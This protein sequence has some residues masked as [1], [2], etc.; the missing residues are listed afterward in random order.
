MNS[1]QMLT[2]INPENQNGGH[3]VNCTEAN[4]PSTASYRKLK[5]CHVPG[6]MNPNQNSISTDVLRTTARE[7]WWLQ[8]VIHLKHS[9]E[10]FNQDE[11]LPL[12]EGVQQ[13]RSL[14]AP[15]TGVPVQTVVKQDGE[16]S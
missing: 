12:R 14:A 3:S 15:H 7:N 13:G 10:D 2:A 9:Q 8:Q 11:W 5:S 6:N 16:D 4:C 1:H